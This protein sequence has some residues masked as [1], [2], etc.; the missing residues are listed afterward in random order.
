V[1]DRWPKNISYESAG[2]PPNPFRRFL[3]STQRQPGF[4]LKL[5]SALCLLSAVIVKQGF[6]FGLELTAGT[7]VGV[8]LLMY[9]I[10]LFKGRRA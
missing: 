8:F 5:L 9:L 2:S 1:S 7:L 10:S 4:R 3:R 6:V